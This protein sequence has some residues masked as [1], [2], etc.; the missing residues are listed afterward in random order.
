MHEE[1][2]FDIGSACFMRGSDSNNLHC[3]LAVVFHTEAVMRAA[4]LGMNNM[5]PPLSPWGLRKV[6][7]R[8]GAEDLF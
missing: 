7:W 1:Q 5:A 4:G 6:I 3:T 2:Q 8:Q